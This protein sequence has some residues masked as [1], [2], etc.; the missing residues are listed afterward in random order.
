MGTWST[1]LHNDTP[2]KLDVQL[3][4]WG[5]VLEIAPG[6]EAWIHLDSPNEGTVDI[7]FQRANIAIWAWPRCRLQIEHE[8]KAILP[9]DYP[10]C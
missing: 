1:R 5:E 4:P 3:K 6:G 10:R 7:D 9:P 2:N 8:G